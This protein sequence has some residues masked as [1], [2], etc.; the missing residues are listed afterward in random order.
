MK[1]ENLIYQVAGKHMC[2]LDPPINYNY[3]NNYFFFFW[4]KIFFLGIIFYSFSN[5]TLRSQT[6]VINNL[7]KDLYASQQDKLPIL[8]ELCKQGS[9]LPS[10]SFMLYAQKAK[11]ISIAKNDFPDRLLSDFY[12]G[13]CY[14][15][16][17]M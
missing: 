9:S 6:S 7:R 11:Q 2:I 1:S 12:A 8:L 16:A 13:K 15:Y 4:K 3:R 17:D 14:V 10:D 5:T